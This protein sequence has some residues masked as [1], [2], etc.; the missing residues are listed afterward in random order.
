MTRAGFGLRSVLVAVMAASVVGMTGCG[1]D[2]GSATAPQ[3]V[4]TN[5]GVTPIDRSPTTSASASQPTIAGIPGTTAVADQPYSFQPQTG[6]TSGTVQFSIA[7]LPAWARFNTATGQLSGTPAASN[8][9]QYPGITISLVSSTKAVAL[10][11]FTITVAAA[12]SKSNS[13]T[14]SWQAPTENSDGSALMDLKGYKVHYGSAPQ[15][16][17]DIIQVA[18]SGLT[19][20]VIQNLPTGT[21]Y[22][23]VTAYNS[24]GKESSLSGEVSTQVD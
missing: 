2:S 19:T 23:A 11:A 4:T 12:T 13:V 22:F 1:G 21:Y 3:T 16:Y 5:Q 17:S 10:P 7:H 6:N 8:V 15:S 9:G 24:S 20:Y 18:N 14:L